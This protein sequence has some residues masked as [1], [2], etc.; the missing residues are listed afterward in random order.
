MLVSSASDKLASDTSHS[1][2]SLS[3]SSSRPAGKRRPRF[4]GTHVVKDGPFSLDESGLRESEES[5]DEQQKGEHAVRLR[6]DDVSPS[7]LPLI[8][9]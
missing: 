5:C 9:V 8:K 1:V 2:T 4:H 7:Y 6:H 3:S